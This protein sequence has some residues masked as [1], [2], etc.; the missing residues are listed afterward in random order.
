M[1]PELSGVPT[2]PLVAL[3]LAGVAVNALS[4]YLAYRVTRSLGTVAAERAL[5]DDT[6]RSPG[7]S[8]DGATVDCREC[9]TENESSYRYCRECVAELPGA[10]GIRENGPGTAGRIV[11]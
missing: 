11:E 10:A 3:V 4:A 2:G 7:V 5:A 9:G 1:V 6:D 8:G